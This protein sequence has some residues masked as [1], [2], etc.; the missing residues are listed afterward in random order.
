MNWISKRLQHH[1]YHPNYLYFLI[2]LFL[3]ILAPPLVGLMARGHLIFQLSFALVLL[4]G[5]FYVST[6]FLEM[7]GAM[8]LSAFIFSFF[9][10]NG[11]ERVFNL[12]ATFSN[13]LLFGFLFVRIMTYLMRRD[14]MDTNS[15]YA[16]VSAFLVLG[17]IGMPLAN[18]IEHYFPGAYRLPESYTYYDFLYYCYITIT[19]VGYGDIT[20]VH[21]LAKALAILLSITGQLYITFVVA[22]IIGKYLADELDGKKEAS[23]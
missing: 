14:R 20:P 21:P 16:S 2:S 12:V 1:F 7:M 17:I 4:M 10:Q 9:I 3:L 5:S 11:G 8:A 15:L 6:T 18:T 13:L 22:I 19:T 23:E